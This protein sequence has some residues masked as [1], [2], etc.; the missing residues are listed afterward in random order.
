VAS[1]PLSTP[2]PLTVT[3]VICTYTEDR[4]ALILEA[5]DSLRRQTRP[6]DE[7]LLVV[8]YNAALAERMRRELD[9]VRVVE[10]THAKGLSGAKNTALHEASGE[11]LAVLDDD[12]TADERWLELLL[13]HFF[14]PDVVAVGSASA[15]HWER[16]RPTWFAPE[17]D[18]TIGCSY[19]GLP[20][21]A[22]PV[23]NV[24]GGAMAMRVA[25]ARTL[26]G[27]DHQL[28]RGGNRFGG[29][30]ETEFCLR[31]GAVAPGARIVY[32][33][34]TT[35]H[36]RV[37]ANRAAWSYVWRRC[38]GE[39]MSKATLGR[40]ARANDAS[41]S[42]AALRTELHYLMHTIPA[43]LWREVRCLRPD[44]AAAIVGAVAA[45]SVG[46]V[47]GKTRAAMGAL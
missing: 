42:G 20:E 38:F 36:H 19:R 4:W 6:A 13:A 14:D 46:F 23:R 5:L 43:A 47:V 40:L 33:P 41:T 26:D 27:F 7:L 15:P 37:P 22:T 17:L 45:T 11:I 1:G 18:W 9:G 34:A 44:A 12:A 3:A 16:E 2:R 35:I 30:E 8:D 21:S 24:F 39:G 28:G 29:A 32:E 25:A 10:N 31:L